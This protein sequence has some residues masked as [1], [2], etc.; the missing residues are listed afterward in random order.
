MRKKGFKIPKPKRVSNVVTGSNGRVYTQPGG[1]YEM[2][3]EYE[4]PSEFITI[5]E[6]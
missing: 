4:V 2:K 6:E 3:F 1:G 5:I